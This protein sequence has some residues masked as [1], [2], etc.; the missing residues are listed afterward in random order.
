[1]LAEQTERPEL[2]IVQKLI[3]RF[4]KD[5]T[6]AVVADTLVLLGEAYHECGGNQDASMLEKPAQVFA[7]YKTQIYDDT[8][9]INI[10]GA[11]TKINII[12]E[13]SNL[14]SKGLAILDIVQ[15]LFDKSRTK[16]WSAGITI[17]GVQCTAP[18]LNNSLCAKLLEHAGWID[19]NVSGVL[20][21]YGEAISAELKTRLQ[22]LRTPEDIAATAPENFIATGTL[23]LLPRPRFWT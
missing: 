22:A 1:M 21:T 2:V 15:K 7:F 11:I 12:K 19:P 9:M 14:T 20:A 3:D 16:N 5:F 10:R 13:N 4:N 6:D 8:Q 17:G 23:S 18:S